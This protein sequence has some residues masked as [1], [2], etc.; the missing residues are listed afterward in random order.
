M[1][2][3][4]CGNWFT[5]HFI[6]ELFLLLE[7][8][9]FKY[10]NPPMRKFITGKRKSKMKP[11]VDQ[12]RSVEMQS[13]KPRA[14]VVFS[15]YNEWSKLDCTLRQSAVDM[16]NE[17]ST[18]CKAYWTWTLYHI[19]MYSICL[20]QNKCKKP[21]IFVKDWMLVIILWTGYF[22]FCCIIEK[23]NP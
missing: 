12:N 10:W 7:L 2:L 16:G 8:L 4:H 17:I 11:G 14:W 22:F 1:H 5:S 3:T 13:W 9:K 18:K 15:K 23:L 20:L 6:P 21:C 19:L